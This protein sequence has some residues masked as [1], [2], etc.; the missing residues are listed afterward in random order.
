MESPLLIE[1][2]KTR[3]T[4][5]LWYSCRCLVGLVDLVTTIVP[6]C[7]Q[8]RLLKWEVEWF[9]VRKIRR[10]FPEEE[11]VGLQQR[12]LCQVGQNRALSIEGVE[13]MHH[14]GLLEMSV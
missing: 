3:S 5:L 2:E 1:P 11:V 6:L 10:Q 8:F 12:S 14:L 9:G 7:R 4:L 13:K